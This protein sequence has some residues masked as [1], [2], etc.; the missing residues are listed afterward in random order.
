MSN[1]NPI[2]N[3]E[4]KNEE[5]EKVGME[6]FED[7]KHQSTEKIVHYSKKSQESKNPENPIKYTLLQKFL[8]E[9][10]GTSLLMFGTVGAPLFVEG[11]LVAVG[12]TCGFTITV[13]IHMFHKISSAHFN[14]SVSLSCYLK[15]Y[16]TLKELFVYI[17]AQIIGAFVGCVLIALC[18]KGKFDRLGA[19]KIQPYLIGVDNGEKID[20]WCYVSALIC[21]LLCTFIIVVYVL[22]ISEK[23]NNLGTSLGLTFGSMIALLVM[24]GANISASSFNPARSLAPAILQVIADGDNEPLKEIWIYIVGPLGGGV[25]AVVYWKIFEI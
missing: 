5:T 24:A 12:L 20:A 7:N 9:L 17:L 21:E 23:N 19:T 16:I 22:S 11:N 2:T 13:I 14:P 10:S 25:L 15:K 18:R 3:E 1:K 6:L 8:A 4:I